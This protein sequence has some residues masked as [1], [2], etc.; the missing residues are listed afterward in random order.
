M[1]IMSLSSNKPSSL[2]PISS[3]YKPSQNI[4]SKS[5]LI[6]LSLLPIAIGGS[7]YS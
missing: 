2:L 7:F 6:P 4:L 1:I 3:S 5:P